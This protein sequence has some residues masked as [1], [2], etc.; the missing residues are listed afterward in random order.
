V[1]SEDAMLF[2][3]IFSSWTLFYNWVDNSNIASL[4]MGILIPTIPVILYV[5]FKHSKLIKLQLTWHQQLKEHAE[6]FHKEAMERNEQLHKEL[7]EHGE[8]MRKEM[9]E[10]WDEEKAS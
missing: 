8:L 10:H 5:R 3:G 9:H 1:R 2:G 4:L 6:A 7:K